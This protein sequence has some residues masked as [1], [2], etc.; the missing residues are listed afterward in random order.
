MPWFPPF[1]P[2]FGTVPCGKGVPPVAATLQDQHEKTIYYNGL[3]KN[4]ESSTKKYSH[5]FV[6]RPD[7]PPPPD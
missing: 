6:R 5:P 7:C 1:L 3:H 4:T 2:L